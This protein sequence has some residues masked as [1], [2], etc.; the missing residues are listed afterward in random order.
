MQTACADQIIAVGLTVTFPM[1]FHSKHYKTL[2]AIAAGGFVGI[3][4]DPS[5]GDYATTAGLVPTRDAIAIEDAKGPYANLIAVR[6][7]DRDEP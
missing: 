5:N 3:P 1:G 2:D 7:V 6:I 4:N